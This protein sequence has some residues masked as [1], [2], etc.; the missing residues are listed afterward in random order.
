MYVLKWSLV[1]KVKAYFV[2]FQVN[3]ML[4]LEMYTKKAFMTP[5]G[6]NY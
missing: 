5:Q 4:F 6:V 2:T 3:K 1:Q